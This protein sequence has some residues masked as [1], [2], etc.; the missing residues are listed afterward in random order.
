MNVD[1]NLA[2]IDI[3]RVVIDYDA[4]RLTKLPKECLR[5]HQVLISI[6]TRDPNHVEEFFAHDAEGH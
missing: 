4:L 1:C 5:A 3:S 6:A 2:L